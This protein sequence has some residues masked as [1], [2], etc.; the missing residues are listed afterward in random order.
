MIA[1]RLALLVPLLTFGCARIEPVGVYEGKSCA[2]G[3]SI[4]S[5]VHAT[6]RPA[7]IDNQI[8]IALDGMR[9]WKTAAY[10]NWD[11][12]FNFDDS[13]SGIPIH[14]RGSF[15]TDGELHLYANAPGG[16]F[17]LKLKK[18]P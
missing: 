5:T 13:I 17:D 10:S 18:V 11:G 7:P 14:Y 15:S 2:E 1:I 6:V 8:A 12:S 9:S 16:R 4:C 3:Q